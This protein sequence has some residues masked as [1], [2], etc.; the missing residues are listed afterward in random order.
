MTE[1][2]LHCTYEEIKKFTDYLDGKADI[3]VLKR[4][5]P[6][7]DCGQSVYARVYMDVELLPPVAK[8]I[9]LNDSGNCPFKG[10]CNGEE[11]CIISSKPTNS[12]VQCDFEFE[13][14]ELYQQREKFREEIIE[15]PQALD[16]FF[17]EGFKR[18]N[19]EQK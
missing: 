19:K 4:S 13:N 17:L 16:K 2:R 9:T 6:Y 18:Q 12:A 15:K 7:A 11:V 10:I 1:V 3:L 14:C 5:K 8:E